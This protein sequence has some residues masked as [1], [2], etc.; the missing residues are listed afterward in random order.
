MSFEQL[1]VDANGRNKKKELE[2]EE[3]AYQFFLEKKIHK[4]SSELLQKLALQISQEFWIDIGSARELI[5]TQ[6]AVLEQKI[7]NSSN[8]EQLHHSLLQAVREAQT[9]IENLSKKHR[10]HLKETIFKTQEIEAYAWKL[11]E[12]FFSPWYQR[13]LNPQNFSDQ[14]LGALF[15]IFD[16]TE[17]VILFVYGLWKWVILTPYHIFLMLRWK[18]RYEGIEKI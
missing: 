9:N 15:G 11:A 1:D 17:A 13:G 18:A 8:P 2:E 10:E 16:T 5:R 14:A 12:R 3:K 7:Q 6:S 4:E